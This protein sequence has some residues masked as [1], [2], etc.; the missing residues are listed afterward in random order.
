MDVKEFD[1]FADEYDKLLTDATFRITGEEPEYFVEYKISDLKRVSES[2]GFKVS[3]ILDFG[4]GV[5]NS[6]PCL[7]NYFPNVDLYG[8]DVS[9][10]SVDIAR[11]RFGELCQFKTFDGEK[12]PYEDSQFDLVIAAVVFHHIPLTQHEVLIREIN[13][14]LRHGGI[15][16]IYELNPLNPLTRYISKTCPF[17]K[18]A[19]LLKQ[20]KM[21]SILKNAGMEIF[22]YEYRMFFP[23]A[24]NRLR[25]FEH[26]LKWLP[27]GGQY[28]VVARKINT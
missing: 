25:V 18:N 7:A 9:D 2:S 5:G 13:R 15:F 19:V 26:Y 11:Q 17:D 22:T 24:L 6:I 21:I 4:V 12:L 3:K 20:N 28:F 1:Q 14:I 23:K 27:L 10:R 16:M 8:V